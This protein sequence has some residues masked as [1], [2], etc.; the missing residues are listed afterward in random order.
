MQQDSLLDYEIAPLKQQRSLLDIEIRGAFSEFPGAILYSR[1]TT[2]HGD[3]L[4]SPNLTVQTVVIFFE[5]D[6]LHICDQKFRQNV[7][8]IKQSLDLQS[9]TDFRS[10]LL[11]WYLL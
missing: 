11:V 7:P 2:L 8:S 1:G 3:Y 9:G 10:F 6:S 5:T 4:A